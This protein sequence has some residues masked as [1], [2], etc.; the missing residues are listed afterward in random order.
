MLPVVRKVQTAVAADETLNHEYLPVTGNP[1]FTAASTVL[2]LGEDSEAIQAKRA[3]GV[4]T[5]SGTGA[6]RLGAELLVDKLGRSVIYY[7]DPTWGELGAS[8]TG[9]EKYANDNVSL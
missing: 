5:L 6:L 1:A 7:S 2:L 4:Q 3:V 9:N 8:V